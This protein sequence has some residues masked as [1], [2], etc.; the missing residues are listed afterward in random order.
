MKD[1]DRDPKADAHLN[2]TIWAATL[3]D[4]R[5]RLTA[6]SPEGGRQADLLLLK[7]LLLIGGLMGD[8]SPPTVKSVRQAREGFATGLSAILE[9]DALL[10]SGSHHQLILDTFARRGIRPEPILRQIQSTKM[11]AA[12]RF[13]GPSRS[14]LVESSLGKGG[15]AKHVPPEEIPETE[16]L[17]SADSL[18]AHFRKQGKPRLSLIAVG[19]IM[20]GGRAR[21]VLAEHGDDYP[22]QA[23]LPLLSRAPIVLGNLEGPLAREAKKR[24]RTYSY[25][26]HPKLAK[27]LV[28]AGINVVTLA[29]NHILDC[30][31]AG[32]LETLEALARTGIASIGAGA[33]K[34][35]AHSP[36]ILGAA[37]LR[38]G[39]L[40]YY[41]NRR[42]AASEKLP[43]SAMDSFE[44]LRAD[45]SALRNE[46]DRI[47]VTFHWGVPY[48]R[49]PSAADRAK[50]RFAIDC[51]ADVVIAHHPHIIQPFEVYRGCPIFFSIGNFVFGSG[52]SQGEGLILGLRFEEDRTVIEVY[53]LYV[54]NRDP[55]VNYQPKILREKG[56]ARIL[57]KLA[58]ISAA[59]GHLLKIGDLG[60]LLTLERRSV[61]CR[62]RQADGN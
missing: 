16:D 28:R 53:P 56:G 3:W 42:T 11:D 20:L 9:G 21:K 22:F 1:Y 5:I 12:F 41:W 55:R 7:A 18:D 43:G 8:I 19:D 36:A 40:G 52:N 60:A 17:L 45:I 59:D 44:E 24:N 62:A 25:R 46:V 29:N 49:E 35:K 48:L 37:A 51:G 57:S 27:S 2:G 58:R 54:K 31:R 34:E 26:V 30:G 61:C 39:F 38:V 13:P 15:L 23:V 32:V 4:L 14:A 6:T 33:D 10:Y 50:A 47:V